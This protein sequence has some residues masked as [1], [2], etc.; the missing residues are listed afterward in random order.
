MVD[1]SDLSWNRYREYLSLLTRLQVPLALRGKFDASDVVQQTL[2]DAPQA[3]DGLVGR[4]EGERIAFLRRILAN[5]L[6]DAV[7]RFAAAG[8]DVTREQMI[9]VVQESSARLDA[10]LADDQIS[11]SERVSRE[12]DL[13]G[14]A[15]GLAELPVDQRLAVEMKHL[16]GCSVAEIATAMN[17][18][19]TAVGGLLRRGLQQLRNQLGEP[20]E[21][22]P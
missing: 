7:R 8:R 4:S 20:D 17:R 10:L 21:S 3:R 19:E 16:R 6:A 13:L 9:A 12:E 2:L 15:A 18:T 22:D 5:N 14:L 1:E 11:P